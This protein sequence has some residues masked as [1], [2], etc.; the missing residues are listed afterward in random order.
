MPDEVVLDDPG[1][2]NSDFIREFDL[3]DDAAVMSLHVTNVW[4]IGRQVEQSKLHDPSRS[5]AL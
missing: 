2:V 3:L 1:I 4:Q 5:L